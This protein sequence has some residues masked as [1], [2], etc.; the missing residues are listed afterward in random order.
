MARPATRRVTTSRAPDPAFRP[1]VGQVRC[2]FITLT[3]PEPEDRVPPTQCPEC[4]R[5]LAGAFVSALA[6]APAPCP[7]CGAELT[8]ARV[9]ASPEAAASSASE[10]DDAPDVPTSDEADVLAGWDPDGVPTDWLDD[11][12]PFPE[13]VAWVA[14]AATAGGIVG[15]VLASRPVRGLLLGA[16]LGAGA[17]AVARQVW[18][19]RD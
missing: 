16:V 18:R 6:D 4:G 8:A 3:A 9:G 19:L 12:A 11:R 1:P 17:A 7:R 14:G 13:D 10:A 5:F 2:A 15:L